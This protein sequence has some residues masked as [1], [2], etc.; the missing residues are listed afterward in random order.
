MRTV[1]RRFRSAALGGEGVGLG[2]GVGE[3]FG[4][5]RGV[6]D[7]VGVGSGVGDG[8]GL[9]LNRAQ[10]PRARI[11]PRAKSRMRVRRG[12]IDRGSYTR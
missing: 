8:V 4:V 5:G 3:K 6:G 11:R 2:S 1:I 10:P 9:G 7:G 12:G